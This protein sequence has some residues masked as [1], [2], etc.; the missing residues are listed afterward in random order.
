ME[1]KKKLYA[2]FYPGQGAQTPGM[3]Q[4]V[5]DSYGAARRI[6]E[7]V[8]EYTSKDI[9][10]L[11]WKTDEDALSRTDNSQMALMISSLLIAS[12]LEEYGIKPACC[13]GFSLGEVVALEQAG[14]ISLKDL[15]YTVEERGKIMQE[16]CDKIK[17]NSKGSPPGM[18]AIV[19]LSQEKVEEIAKRIPGLYLSNFNSNK[20]IVV[21]GTGEVLEKACKIYI[22]NGARRA[23]LLKVAGPF[24]SPLMAEAATKFSS[25][26]SNVK[27]NTPKAHFFSNLT[28]K[29]VKEAEAIKAN[30][31][32]HL[33]NSVKWTTQEASLY[34]FMKDGSK[35]GIKYQ[36]LEV[37][38]GQ[39]L[40]GLWKKTEYEAEY[41]CLAI[42]SAS[43]IKALCDKCE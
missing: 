3:M 33:T 32:L 17:E 6:L 39:V 15:V 2:F 28:G 30:L 43:S 38:A 27:F 36:V 10:K 9:K 19:G 14:V 21:S 12:V 22:D 4:D 16:V 31:L 35:E 34:N 18:A 8:Q 37:G 42:N 5:Y 7:E 23:L 11:L 13:M 41:P 20:Q 25:V 24:H 40:T 1:E 26:L 29:E